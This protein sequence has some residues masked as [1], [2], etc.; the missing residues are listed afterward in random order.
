MATSSIKRTI[1]KKRTKKFHRFMKSHL[2][3]T[4]GNSFIKMRTGWRKPKGIDN[5]VRRKFQG[6][7]VMPNIGYGSNKKTK[8]MMPSGF[9][10]FTVSNLKDMEMLVMHNTKFAVEI[11]HNV[12]SRNRRNLVERAAQ[13][14]LYVTNK[15]G[16]VT[17]EE[18]E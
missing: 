2:N 13:L 1:V 5:R 9:Y 15:M 10:K 12:A 18:A 6:T 4:K 11:A 14:G 7:T 16:R 17:T 3:K 8:H